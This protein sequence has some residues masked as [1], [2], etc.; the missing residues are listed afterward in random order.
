M[1]KEQY[2]LPDIGDPRNFVLELQRILDIIAQ[3]LNYMDADGD[4]VK[5]NGKKITDLNPGVASNDGIRLDQAFLLSDLVSVILGTLNQI[6]VTDNGNKTITLSTPQDIDTNA[7]VTFD[8]LSVD[9]IDLNLL[10]TTVGAEG[11]FKWNADD[12]TPEIGMPGGNV[13]LQI[14]QEMLTPRAKAVGSDIDNG[15][16]V[17]V[18]G[19]SGSKPEMTLA[20]ADA[21]ATSECVIAMATE[22]ISQNQNGYFTAF[23]LVRD[24][25]TDPVTYSDGDI[26][27]LSA[28]T[29]GAYTN[30]KP[31][32]PN[33]A[34]KI[35]TVI[36]AHATEGI[37]FIA[38]VPRIQGYSDTYGMTATRIPYADANGFLTESA[39]LLFDGTHFYLKQITLNHIL[40]LVMIYQFTMTA[41][42]DISKQ[43]KLQQVTLI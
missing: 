34:I 21:L 32:S 41:Q 39:I 13:N 9:Y 19:A 15:E 40:V 36:K 1:P 17:Y 7:D 37:I 31:T 14:G 29:A 3:R 23:G 42:T 2:I 18:S 26:L 25:N 10:S 6:T 24:V 5:F 11:R 28:A 12:G 30:V 20:K 35:G 33:Y 43:M 16:L 22:N 4:N 38:V 8:S 27:Y